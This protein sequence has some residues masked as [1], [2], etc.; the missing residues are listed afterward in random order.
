MRDRPRRLAVVAPPGA[1]LKRLSALAPR[2]ASDADRDEAYLALVRQCPCI[3][4]GMDPAAEAAHIRMQSAA[5]GKRGGIS[6]K[7]ADRWTL[8]L[9]RG[10]HRMDDDALHNVGEVVFF[11]RLGFH[12]LYVCEK[13]YAQRGDLVAMRAV[14]MNAIAE[15][16]VGKVFRT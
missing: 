13:L 7:P 2:L 14:V 10:C 9:D 16:S 4:C 1:L 15:R 3:R 6:K 11:Y 8:P 5:H 12:P